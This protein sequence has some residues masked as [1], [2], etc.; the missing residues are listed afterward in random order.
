[1]LKPRMLDSQDQQ[2]QGTPGDQLP[3]VEPRPPR[4]QSDLFEDDDDTGERFIRG[5][6]ADSDTELEDEDGGPG[7]GQQGEEMAG[8]RE[9]EELLRNAASY[10]MSDQLQPRSGAC[11]PGGAGYTPRSSAIQ[12]EEA[13]AA[14]AVEPL[15]ADA[16]RQAQVPSSPPGQ[17]SPTLQ[18]KFDRF[19]ERKSAGLDPNAGIKGRRDFKNPSLYE[20]LV[21]MFGIDEKGT[22]FRADVY[23]PKSFRPEDFYDE[24]GERQ[25]AAEARRKR[26]QQ[27]SSGTESKSATATTLAHSPA[28]KE[29]TAPAASRRPNS[30][31][32]P[33]AGP[34][35]RSRIGDG[36]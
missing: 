9:E 31:P 1:M 22:N 21:N 14:A 29:S 27:M 20:T 3:L 11:T 2:Q 10:V 25:A 36:K 32:D 28:Q 8:E 13:L 12:E 17:C 5:G 23:D 19:F 15:S 35:R 4:R 24:L 34:A 18:Q 33:K 6:D 26:Q 7:T 30:M 16:P